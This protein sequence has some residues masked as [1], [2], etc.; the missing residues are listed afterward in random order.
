MFTYCSYKST[1]I[2]RRY[3]IIQIDS[4]YNLHA[5]KTK[6]F[7]CS[8]VNVKYYAAVQDMITFSSQTLRRRWSWFQLVQPQLDKPIVVFIL[9]EFCK[10][11]LHK[12]SVI[13]HFL[14]VYTTSSHSSTGIHS[15]V[16]FHFFPSSQYFI[17]ISNFHGFICPHAYRFFFSPVDSRFSHIFFN[18][19]EPFFYFESLFILFQVSFTITTLT[20]MNKINLKVIHIQLHFIVF[21]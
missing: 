1:Y 2:A 12:I 14:H 8:G 19:I 3:F 13:P 21:C 7:I 4:L 16:Y 10:H 11:V 15:S 20:A 17:H 9:Y 18:V 5:T 6:C